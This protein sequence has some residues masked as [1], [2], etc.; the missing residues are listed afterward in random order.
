[1]YTKDVWFD[2]AKRMLIGIVCTYIQ[3]GIVCDCTLS[4]IIN[5]VRIENRN[6]NTPNIS[7][8]S[9]D[10][11]VCMVLFCTVIAPS[12]SKLGNTF[13]AFTA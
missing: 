3:Y 9:I 4:Q 13:D 1:M 10:A 11:I 7:S 2:S 12:V 6:L 5:I 8:L